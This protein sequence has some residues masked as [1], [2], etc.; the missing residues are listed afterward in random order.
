VTVD[1]EILQRAEQI[2]SAGPVVKPWDHGPFCP[3]CAIAQAKG[4]IETERGLS[5][6]A[7]DG[8]LALARAALGKPP[9]HVFSQHDALTLVRRVIDA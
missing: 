9:M 1:R 4:V 2:I 5:W 7:Y 8:A 6:D 3:W